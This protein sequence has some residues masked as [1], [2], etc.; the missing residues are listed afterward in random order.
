MK[1]NE[2]SV[3]E[4]LEALYRLQKIDSQIDKINF[5]KGE[6]PLEVGEMNDEI[7]GFNTRLSNV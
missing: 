7:I 1:R 6:L 5:I 4:K 2:V 3:E